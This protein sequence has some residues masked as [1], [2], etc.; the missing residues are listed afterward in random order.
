MS[1]KVVISVTFF[2]LDLLKY[3]ILLILVVYMF[4]IC[5]LCV[6]HGIANFVQVLS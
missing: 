4:F 5:V 1:K 2:I 3:S 6:S